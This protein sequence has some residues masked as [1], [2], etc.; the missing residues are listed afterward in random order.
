MRWNIIV[1]MLALAAGAATRAAE[2]ELET[3]RRALR[4]F[5]DSARAGDFAAAARVLDIPEARRASEGP[6]LARQLKLV[7]DQQLWLDW[8]RISDEPDGD[9]VDGPGAD[10]VGNVPLGSALVPI[11]VVRTG[12]VWRIGPGVVAAIPSLYAAHGPG[13]IGERLPPILTDVRFL[14]V[15]AWQWIGLAAALALA[16]VVAFAF[17]VLGRRV[18]LRVTR[19]T[20]FKWDDL[21]VDAASGPARL[22]L[23]IAIFA[24]TARMLRL[25]VPAQQAI[26]QILRI[27][28]ISLFSWAGLRAL[29][30]GAEVLA[31]GMSLGA[32][33]GA[34]RARLTQ[35][36][37]LKRVAG[38]VVIVVG[39][40]LVL[41]QFDALRAV[42][43]SLLASAGVAGIVVGLAAQRSIAT[44]LA[45]LQISLTQPVRVGD[46]VVIEGEWGTIEEIT[47]TYVV[48]R[49]WDLR[50]L[51]VPIT[52]ILDAPFQ[53]W[54]RSGSEI[55]GTVFLH[56]DYR[57]P[58]DAVRRELERF[59]ATRPEWDGK[60]VGLQVTNA[61]DRT[62]EIRAL[63]S[64]MDASRN[65]DL[66][67]AVREHLLAFLQRLDG[68]ANLPRTRIESSG[69]RSLRNVVATGAVAATSL[70][71]REG[72]DRGGG[73]ARV[74]PSSS[75]DGPRRA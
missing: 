28:A 23:G 72:E 69:L 41:L 38:F 49:I 61:M 59:V 3:P 12:G 31:G 47:L 34:A 15:Q 44:L 32:P 35:I 63:V 5:I 70:A 11:R 58:V 74:T 43:T 46:V 36:M 13:W 71:D 39:G 18:A 22:L 52:R 56:A 24:G 67:C 51:V 26:D 2:P 64:S 50:R 25:A 7:L 45:G 66:R 16:V 1:L 40:A 17:G 4:A 54:T 55:L 10:V 48:V 60:V 62:V 68:G 42:G 19:H 65:W 9:P 53:N 73:D 8:D 21:L 20:R 75:T 33:D 29:R 30:F 57:L 6:R 27:A 14:E 37:V